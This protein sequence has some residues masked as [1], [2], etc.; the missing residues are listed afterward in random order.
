MYALLDGPLHE[1]VAGDERRGP[2]EDLLP[3][4][5]EG[6][7]DGV[8]ESATQGLLTVV[9][10]GVRGDALL[11]RGACASHGKSNAGLDAGRR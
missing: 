5:A 10:Q 11:S 3:G 6:V 9:G 8:V 7:E 2:E 1:R 4:A